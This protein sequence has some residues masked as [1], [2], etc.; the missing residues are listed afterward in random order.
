MVATLPPP[1]PPMRRRLPA[2]SR[3]T[4]R[5]R[6]QQ[7]RRWRRVADP[8]VAHRG[9]SPKLLAKGCRGGHRPEQ[10]DLV[11]CSLGSWGRMAMTREG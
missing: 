8:V 10:N 6:T 5:Q 4:R 2:V 7:R 1:T 11:A 3:C 9:I